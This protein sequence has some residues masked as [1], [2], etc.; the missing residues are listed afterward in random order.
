MALAVITMVAEGDN[1]SDVITA[2][3]AAILT[4]IWAVTTARGL[5]A[6]SGEILR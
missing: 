3:G 2:I 6:T 1:L 5:P 4:P